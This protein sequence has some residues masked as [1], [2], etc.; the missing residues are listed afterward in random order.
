MEA[1]RKNEANLLP[2]EATAQQ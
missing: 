1:G 2:L